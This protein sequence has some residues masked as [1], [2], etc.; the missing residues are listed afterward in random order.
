MK[1]KEIS[2]KIRKMKKCLSLYFSHFDTA[3][4]QG[5]KRQPTCQLMLE[6]SDKSTSSE[7]C[8]QV[9]LRERKTSLKDLIDITTDVHLGERP[10]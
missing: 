10:G 9:L 3:Q 4:N 5:A 1:G 7:I 2:F 8:V 6:T